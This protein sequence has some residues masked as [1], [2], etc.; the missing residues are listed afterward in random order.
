MLT[1]ADTPTI[2][3][4]ILKRLD[5]EP[6]VEVCETLVVPIV[7]DIP[8]PNEWHTDPERGIERYC[9][10]V[11]ANYDVLSERVEHIGVGVLCRLGHM[12]VTK[13][14]FDLPPEF[15]HQHLL[16]EIDEI[17]EQM[18]AAR[19]DFFGR[20]AKLRD[21]EVQLAGTGLRGRWAS[22]G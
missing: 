21:P 3:N 20:G 4:A 8:H 16:N 11:D 6:G 5:T 12:L 19:L 1:Y 2:R 18:K 10:F 22:Y 13:S 9:A 7:R 14:R 17:A 15:T